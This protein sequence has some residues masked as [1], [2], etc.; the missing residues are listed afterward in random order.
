MR[1][2]VVVVLVTLLASCGSGNRSESLHSSDVVAVATQGA[3]EG[4]QLEVKSG[5]PKW[6]AVRVALPTDLPAR[7]PQ[8]GCTLG[9]ITTLRLRGGNTIAYGPCHRP[10]SIDALRIILSRS[11]ASSASPSIGRSATTPLLY[12]SGLMRLDPPGSATA[13]VPAVEALATAG[14]STPGDVP[15]V[16]LGRLTV[17]DYMRGSKRLVDHRLVWLVVYPHHD[18]QLRGCVPK[19]CPPAFGQVLMPIDARTGVSLGRWS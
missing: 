15:E 19:G 2:A 1:S 7:P 11:N 16:L 13:P 8:N 12:R 4:P 9:N 3:P 17:F 5:D 10:A 18:L 14:G 6:S